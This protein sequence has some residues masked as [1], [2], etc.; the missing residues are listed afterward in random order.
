MK[1]NAIILYFFTTVIAVFGLLTLY[2][3]SSVIF[4]LFGVR[5]QEGN[6]VMFIVWANFISSLLYL[7]TSYG[8][9]T[10]KTWSIKPITVALLILIAAFF[11]LIIYIQLG[12][13]FEEKTVYGMIFRTAL[14]LIFTLFVKRKTTLWKNHSF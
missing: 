10:T 13:I 11:G 9:F 4:D 6:Y 12:G 5:A 8:L 1:K 7:G 2:L 14:T 3:S